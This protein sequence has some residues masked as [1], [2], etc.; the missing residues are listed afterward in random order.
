MKTNCIIIHGCPSNREKA[1]SAETRTYDKHWIPWTKDKL[2]A[3]DIPT[4]T[5]LMPDPWQPSYEKFKAEFEKQEV[6]ESSIL[7][8]HLRWLGETKQK[9]AKLILVAPWAIGKKN[10]EVRRAF[11]GYVIDPTITDR[12]GEIIYFTAD[13]ED[14]DGKESLKMIH[15]I[16]GGKII[17]LSGRGHYTTSDMGT[18]EFPE[19]L[20]QIISFDNRKAIILA[21]NS[22]KQIFIQDRRDYKKPD[23]GY[24]GGEIEKEETSIEAVI[25]ES[26]EELSIDIKE[27]DLIY[28]GIA[29]TFWEGKRIIKYMY[30]YRTEQVYFNIK[31]G[32]GGLWCTFDEAQ[33]RLDVKDGFDEV[34][35]RIIEKQL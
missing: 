18:A 20:E 16:I 21:I 25:R 10:D 24:F 31:E 33:N 6:N 23:W 32:K 9:I 30:L 34:V 1:M 13:D 5:P 4:Q 12:V 11:Y 22:Q 35:K 27:N 8:G 28:L 17:S 26:K 19:L 15:K 14:A 3:L 2:I 29:V 7:I